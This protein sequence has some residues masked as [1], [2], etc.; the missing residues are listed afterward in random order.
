MLLSYVLLIGFML[1]LLSIVAFVIAL[2]TGN[3]T[4]APTMRDWQP[5]GPFR[6]RPQ[7]QERLS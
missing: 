6:Y 7:D 2:Y 1:C 5:S 3:K 4:P